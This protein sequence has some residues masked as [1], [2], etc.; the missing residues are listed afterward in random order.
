M[1]KTKQSLVIKE[2]FADSYHL[3]LQSSYE[4]VLISL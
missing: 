2:E 4:G 1:E 3:I